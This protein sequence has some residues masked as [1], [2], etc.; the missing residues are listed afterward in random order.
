MATSKEAGKRYTNEERLDLVDLLVEEHWM[1]DAE[2]ELRAQLL[3]SPKPRFIVVGQD[4]AQLHADHDA[5]D[6]KGVSEEHPA[7]FC[8]SARLQVIADFMARHMRTSE[9]W[10]LL[11]LEVLAHGDVDLEWEISRSRSSFREPGVGV[12]LL[13]LEKDPVPED[14]EDDEAW[15]RHEDQ[16]RWVLLESA[17]ASA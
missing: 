5:D 4:T 14:D 17:D 12:R 15:V 16:S 13:L 8:C 7:E 9:D 3:A 6:E 10:E 11:H 1:E 2:A